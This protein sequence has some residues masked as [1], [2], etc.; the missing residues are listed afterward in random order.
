MYHQFQRLDSHLAQKMLIYSCVVED[1]FNS[2]Y[3]DQKKDLI[4]MSRQTKQQLAEKSYHGSVD[5][6]YSIFTEQTFDGPIHAKLVKVVGKAV[7]A[8]LRHKLS[9]YQLLLLTQIV[10]LYHFLS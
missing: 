1:K 8:E 4:H 3:L 6:F 5:K 10:H 2:T 7:K 9:I